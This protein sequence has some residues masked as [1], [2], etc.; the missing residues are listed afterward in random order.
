[1]AWYNQNATRLQNA[2]SYIE[3]EKEVDE[4]I[5]YSKKEERKKVFNEVSALLETTQDESVLIEKLYEKVV[6]GRKNQFSLEEEL[7][8]LNVWKILQGRA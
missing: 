6:E 4:M 7:I 5:N 2:K 1:M 3:E 8:Y